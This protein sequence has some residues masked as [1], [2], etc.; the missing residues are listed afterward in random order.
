MLADDLDVMEYG[1]HFDSLG[2]PEDLVFLEW[3][4]LI[5]AAM[6]GVLS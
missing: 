4:I 5:I 1:T 3:G 6:L 2:T